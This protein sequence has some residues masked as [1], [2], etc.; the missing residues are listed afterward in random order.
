VSV[1]ADCSTLSVPLRL[2]PLKETMAVTL[3]Y[4]Q[5]FLQRTLQ[6]LGTRRGMAPSSSPSDLR[7][8]AS[9]PLLHRADQLI[10]PGKAIA[11]FIGLPPSPPRPLASPPA[12]LGS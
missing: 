3:E 10:G 2:Q 9:D 8:L 6:R 12:L 11:G 7:T 5:A 1:I 4:V